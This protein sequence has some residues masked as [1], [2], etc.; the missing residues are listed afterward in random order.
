MRFETAL[1]LKEEILDALP[2]MSRARGEFPVPIGIGVAMGMGRDDFRVAVR[3]QRPEDFNA[4]ARAYLLNLVGDRELDIRYTGI[5][6][7]MGRCVTVGAS[8]AHRFG[9]AGTL[10]F[11]ARRNRDG[12]LGFV[13]ANHVIAALDQGKEGDEIIHPAPADGRGDGA[14]CIGLLAGDY[15]RLNV[16]GPRTV[17]CA[18]ARLVDGIDVETSSVGNGEHLRAEA[19]PAAAR[20]EVSKVG[21]TTGRTY[22][23]ITAFALDDFA[24]KYAFGEALFRNQIEIESTTLA[25][26]S[27]RGDSG[28]AVFSAAG[29]MIG[30]IYARSG[31]GGQSNAGLT[32]A[33]PISVVLDALDVT[34]A[35]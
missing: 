27:G 25:S 5:I 22:G 2:A 18:F 11:F 29:E 6:E 21:R 35:A 9:R 34:V 24:V 30:L 17:D 3:P 26:F 10:G 31:A 8:A 23:R 1:D 7:P 32:F 19:L 20:M 33:N 16:R 4:T 15:P 12:A 14:K 28:S 13:S